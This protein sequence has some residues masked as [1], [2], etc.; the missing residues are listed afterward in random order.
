MRHSTCAYIMII[1]T[2]RSGGPAFLSM[3]TCATSWRHTVPL[4]QRDERRSIWVFFPFFLLVPNLSAGPSGVISVGRAGRSSP[5]LYSSPMRPHLFSQRG[6]GGGSCPR[7]RQTATPQAA[8]AASQWKL[9]P[10]SGWQC[11]SGRH[12][13]N[14]RSVG[15]SQ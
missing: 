10:T 3:R 1:T 8:H 14:G 13:V 2:H 9:S 5:L 15:K 11:L 4:L 6:G 12:G 7:N